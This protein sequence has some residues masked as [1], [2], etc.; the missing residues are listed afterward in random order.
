MRPRSPLPPRALARR[1]GT[2]ALALAAAVASPACEGCRPT[3]GAATTPPTAPGAPTL[4]LYLTSDLAGALEPCGCVKDQLGGLDH[5]AAWIAAERGKAPDSLFVT[6]GPLFFMDP[7]LKG[8]RAAQERTKAATLARS[9]K[10]LG[11]A[12]FAPG[13]NDWAAGDAELASLGEASGGALL[14]GNVSASGRALQGSVVRE[15]RGVKIAFVGVSTPDRAEVAG[16]PG[17]EVGS[18]TEF[19]KREVEKVRA[20][21]AKIVIVLAAT[22]RG[23]AKRIA[24]V[25]P[26]ATAIVVGSPGSSGE[27]NTTGEPPERVGD[28]LVLETGNHLQH[29]GVLDLYVRDESYA[30]ADGSGLD[31]AKKRADLDRRIQELR[32]R[33][34]Q[35]EGSS[36]VPRADVDA[37]RAELAKLVGERK[38]LDDRP[39]PASGSFFRYQQ[40]EV[41]DALGSDPATHAELVAYYKKVNDANKEAFASKLPRPAEDGNGFA[42]VDA[43]VP[44]HKEAYEVWK[45]TPHS[46]AYATLVKQFKEYNLDCVAC[47]VTGYDLPGGSTVAHVEKLTDV[48]CEVCHGPSQKHVKNP[49]VP[50]P[51]RSP[52]AS[53]CPDCH[54]PPHVHV[55]DAL[56]KL[57]EVLGPGHGL[58]LPPK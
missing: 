47:H 12:A 17:I 30:F 38:A 57:P 52:P 28:V 58:P 13:R 22:G 36:T 29:I 27:A 3:G 43:C 20:A 34:A 8:D 4:R 40:V 54:H 31:Q 41:R 1:H 35:W 10:G 39:P 50:V 14:A 18:P 37:R 56:A 21:G 2:L 55:F 53:R 33:I 48:Q 44:C 15:V 23:E 25:V 49:K 26:N 5:A 6:A 51:V 19:A 46:R 45:K 16:P 9:L 7:T 32:G 24:D 42:G 11:F